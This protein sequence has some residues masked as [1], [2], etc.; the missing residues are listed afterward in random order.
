MEA[1]RVL[2][3][4]VMVEP[5]EVQLAKRVGMFEPEVDDLDS[6]S[7]APVDPHGV[8]LL[9]NYESDKTSPS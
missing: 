1:V 2:D 8:D 5:V 7:F 4:P 6:L 3:L 9:K